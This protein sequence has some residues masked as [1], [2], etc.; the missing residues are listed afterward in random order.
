MSLVLSRG[1]AQS[2]VVAGNIRITVFSTTRVK[3]VIDA[4][5]DVHVRRGEIAEV[6]NNG[7]TVLK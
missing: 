7:I 3:V 4:P 5:P 6:K 1:N 2:I